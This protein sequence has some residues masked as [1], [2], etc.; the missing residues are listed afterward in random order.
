MLNSKTARLIIA[1]IAAVLIWGYVVGEV[2]PSKTKTIR[3]I[4]ITY[5]YEDTLNERGLAISGA[6]EDSISLEVS[7]ARAILGYISPNDISATINVAS[8]QKGENEMSITIKV[9]SGIT[10][11]KQSVT[12]TTVNVESLAQK[13][14]GITVAYAGD[15]APGDQGSTVN[16]SSNQV[17]I[18]G[19]ESLVEKVASVHGI[20][21]AANVS[22]KLSAVAC[23]LYPVDA[24]G[25]EVSGIKLSQRSVSV[26]SIIARNKDVP[27]EIS[28]KDGDEDKYIRE[29]SAP[30]SVK[31]FGNVDAL[32][33]VEKLSADVDI[34]TLKE[35]G[36]IEL[37]L[38]LP[39]GVTLSEGEKPIVSVIVIPIEE[40]K[41]SFKAEDITVKG[42][43]DGNSYKFAD[44]LEV[45]VTASDQKS[46]LDAL[47]QN[48]FSLSVDVS[49]LTSS[50]QVE[51]I[52]ECNKDL[53][54]MSV[55]PKSVNVEI[56]DVTD[57]QAD[58]N[59]GDNNGNTNG[60]GNGNGN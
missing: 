41:I 12:R 1:L 9:P 56:S 5:T 20:V 57:G 49:K 54:G 37:K 52:V 58:N 53:R 15:F 46:V 55:E 35:D 40:K 27:L 39:E 44:N 25:K 24:D 32:E 26:T 23:Q 11:N 4:P 47:G 36:E 48:A 59:S 14:T 51:L 3:N 45:V 34:S 18:S 42:A 33:K 60:N 31:V 21:D 10:V 29:V 22:E 16:I 7:G 2:N 19:A 50:G 30:E 8:A 38:T 6:E 43:S 17:I 13:P 28:Y